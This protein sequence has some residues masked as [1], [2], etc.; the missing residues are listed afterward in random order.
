ME[1]ED[2]IPLANYVDPFDYFAGQVL[3]R[4]VVP[5][6][7]PCYDPKETAESAYIYAIEMIKARRDAKEFLKEAGY[8]AEN[9]SKR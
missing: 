3:S 4:L 6:S 9:F 1:N 5:E 8:T 2:I 7:D